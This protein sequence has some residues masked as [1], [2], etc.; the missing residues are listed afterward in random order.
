MLS[1]HVISLIAVVP[2]PN[3][4]LGR[5]LLGWRWK[6]DRH[7]STKSTYASIVHEVSS[8][9]HFN[10]K[11]IW[12]LQLLQRVK[13]FLWLVA[14]HLLLTNAE[15]LQRHIAP[16]DLCSICNTNAETMDHVLRK[17]PAEKRVWQ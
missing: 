14:H 16:L 11:M 5:D 10:W 12:N 8:D 15:R 1:A 6:H 4:L 3:M 7:F 17:C 13:M 9:R 2:S